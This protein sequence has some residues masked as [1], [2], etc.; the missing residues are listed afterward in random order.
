MQ[1]VARAFAREGAR[2]YLV[3]RTEEKLDD[4]ADEIRSKGGTA[5]TSV[6]DALDEG[7]VDQFVAEVVRQ[8]G[9][10]D[11]SFNLISYEDIQKPLL[12]LGVE[13]FI[14]PIM[15]A[16]RSQFLT[17]KAAIRYMAK[18]GTGVIL[19]FGGG[20]PQT[21]PGLGGFKVA[22]DAIEGLRRQWA[23][24]FGKQGIWVVTLKTGGVIETIPMDSPERDEI[25]A[26]IQD[27]NISCGAIVD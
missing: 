7:A 20:G 13:E 10:V 17:S 18:R 21:S 1:L 22:L 23:I 8:A 11:I 2:V 16:M 5:E 25:M 9:Y 6:V 4:V 24:E 26:S 14:Q 27:V 3:G 15:N 12:A 19:H